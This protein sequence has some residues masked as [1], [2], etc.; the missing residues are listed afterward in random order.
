[1]QSCSSDGDPNDKIIGK[2]ILVERMES[3]TQVDLGCLQYF[4]IEFKTNHEK[5][6][7]YLDYDSTPEECRGF[8]FFLMYWEKND[9]KYLT[10][11]RPYDINGEFFFDGDYLVSDSRDIPNKRFIYERLN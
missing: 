2:W 9:D 5:I 7:T 6:G 11:Q 10:Y 4:Y 8:D 3:G 1:L